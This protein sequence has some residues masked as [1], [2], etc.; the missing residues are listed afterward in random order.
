MTSSLFLQNVIAIVWDFD[1]TL[2]PGY[3]Q[4]PLF[5]AYGVDAET[6]W[7]EV[8]AL[9]EFHR[10]NGL[11]LVSPD[12]LYLNHMLTYVRQGV[13]AGLN[14]QRLRELGG[15]L[16][17]YMG[18][19]AIFESLRA[20]LAA[21]AGAR[22]HEITLEYYV[23][24][25]GLRQMI[26]GSPIAPY[27]DGI[28]ACEFVEIEPG[29]GFLSPDV[30]KESSNPG[31]I[32]QVG[33]VLDNT[34][35]T[36]AI[37]EINKGTNRF[38]EIAVNSSIRPED[39]RVP[40]QNMVYVADGPSDIPVFSVVNSQGGRTYAVYAPGSE[41]DFAQADQLRADGRVQA[42][43]EAN[44]VAGSQ[45]TMWL[46]RAVEAI[47]DRITADRNRV[48]DSKVGRPPRHIT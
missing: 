23:V 13:F 27:L 20:R 39:R 36:R 26:L 19:P 10:A 2:I 33:Y 7:E 37:F 14:N 30:A 24:S 8:N 48:L 38:P 44:Y 31:S 3:M 12:S 17:L 29:P 1:K 47:A 42:F 15:E 4:A 41:A 45:T 46:S 35:K 16:E 34:T 11:E 9:P 40:F 21:H 28:W 25:T 22:Q 5:G 18:V 6:F 32:C 43:G